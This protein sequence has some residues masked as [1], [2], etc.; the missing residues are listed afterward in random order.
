MPIYRIED[1]D[2]GTSQVVA[3]DAYQAADAY[4]QRE[5]AGDA[6]DTMRVRVV[7]EAT[8]ES[9]MVSC[10]VTMEPNFDLS[11]VKQAEPKA[12]R[13]IRGTRLSARTRTP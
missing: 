4:F 2:S 12:K 6:F 5:W 9:W 10:R 8:N 1:P 13:K 7:D 3:R 11:I